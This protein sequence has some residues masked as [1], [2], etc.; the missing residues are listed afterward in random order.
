MSRR[1]TSTHSGSPRRGWCELKEESAP[2]S[3]PGSVHSPDSFRT[4]RTEWFLDVPSERAAPAVV[5][6]SLPD[7]PAI[8]GPEA[9]PR[10][11]VRVWVV[12]TASGLRI[13]P[14]SSAR[15]IGG[16]LMR[17]VAEEL[18]QQSLEIIDTLTS[19]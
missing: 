11:D 18:D 13:L 19:R 7:L 12:P 17:L 15:P 14:A 3:A 16:R 2:V 4:V 1:K 6:P 8:P 9:A 10:P 5:I